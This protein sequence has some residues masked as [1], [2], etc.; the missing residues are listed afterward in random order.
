MIR[1]RFAAFLQ[2]GDFALDLQDDA[3]VEVLGVFGPSGSGKTSLLEVIAGLR[4]PERGLV[5]VADHTL[6]DTGAGVNVPAHYREVGY[7]PQDVALFP[8]LDVRRNLLY[9]TRKPAGG[10]RQPA[11]V[12]RQK[13]EGRRQNETG[14]R[15][16]A[17][18]TPRKAEGKRQKAENTT[19]NEAGNFR[20][21]SPASR[22]PTPDSRHDL[23]HVCDTL[24]IAHLVER[25][26]RDLSGGE[27]Q[28]VAIGRALMSA[29]RILLLDEPLT[30]VDRGRKDRILPYLLRI[31]RD[32]HVP[33]IYVTHDAREMRE[34]ADRVLR[35]DGGRVVDAGVPAEVLGRGEKT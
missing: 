27:R 22:L 13:A 30:A 15:Q 1:L 2:Q 4:T 34:I 24:E 23:E 6:L 33:M 10:N 29:P 25:S 3:T 28:R 12:T 19:R 18:G 32:L 5:R 35:L 9:G 17:D 16:P 11:D 31:R 20:L 21:A 26:V 8:H 14:N 7:V